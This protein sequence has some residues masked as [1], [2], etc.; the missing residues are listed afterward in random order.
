MGS[1]NVLLLP[2]DIDPLCRELRDAK[3]KTQPDEVKRSR[4]W[5]TADYRDRGNST[6]D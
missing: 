3:T 2:E 5:L 1:M 4:E 6:N